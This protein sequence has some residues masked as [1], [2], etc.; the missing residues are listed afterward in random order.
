MRFTNVDLPTFG[1]PT[2]ASTGTGPDAVPDSVGM[3]VT[4]RAR[5]QRSRE[6]A[7]GGA[8]RPGEVLAHVLEDLLGDVA[9]H[10]RRAGPRHGREADRVSV[11]DVDARPSR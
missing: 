9:E 2:T 11:D 3:S 6:A 4:G 10:L 8:L 7:L 1:R 5:W